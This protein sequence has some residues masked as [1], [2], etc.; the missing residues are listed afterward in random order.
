MADID[1]Q[2]SS[3]ERTKSYD[4]ELAPLKARLPTPYYRTKNRDQ[5]TRQVA[6][7]GFSLLE[8]QGILRARLTECL[9]TGI[10]GPSESSY[11][12][13]EPS[14]ALHRTDY[15]V[16]LLMLAMNGKD[17]RDWVDLYAVSEVWGSLE[18][19]AV[20]SA[21]KTHISTPAQSLRKLRK[22]ILATPISRIAQLEAPP[23]FDDPGVLKSRVITAVDKAVCSLNRA[24]LRYKRGLY[25]AVDGRAIAA[26]KKPH[27]VRLPR[28]RSIGAD[29]GSGS[30]LVLWPV[31]DHR[32]YSG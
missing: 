29:S 26:G 16:N 7:L 17:A 25:V 9:T 4:R 10:V 21:L 31:A 27:E 23:A 19:L 24:S 15:A 14:G 30:D 13:R 3:A 12:P 1:D 11:F 18:G 32:R 8:G 20:G 2:A 28:V 5:L 22:I 6:K